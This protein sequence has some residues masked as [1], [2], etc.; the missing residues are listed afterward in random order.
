MALVREWLRPLAPLGVTLISPGVTDG[1]DNRSFNNVDLP[2]FQFGADYLDALMIH[3]TDADTFDH[4]KAED[5]RYDAA[6]VAY[7]LLTAANSEQNVP[8]GPSPLASEGE[9]EVMRL[10]RLLHVH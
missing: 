7:T 9:L 3:H 2:N 4:L 8:R 10:V 5:L 1:A 6:I